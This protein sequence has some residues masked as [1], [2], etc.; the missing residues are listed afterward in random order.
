MSGSLQL[1]Y[2]LNFAIGVDDHLRPKWPPQPLYKENLGTP[3]AKRLYSILHNMWFK[4]I[5]PND[6]ELESIFETRRDFIR[7]EFDLPI[8]STLMQALWYVY[9]T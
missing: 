3:D 9:Q 2:N 6:I 8:S 5:E 4:S 1:K 7:A